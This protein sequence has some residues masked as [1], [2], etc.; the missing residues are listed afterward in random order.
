MRPAEGGS[1]ERIGGGEGESESTQPPTL[2]PRSS[3]SHCSPKR[4]IPPPPQSKPP[5]LAAVHGVDARELEKRP[6]IGRRRGRGAFHLRAEEEE[7]IM[8]DH[9]RRERGTGRSAPCLVYIGLRWADAQRW[10]RGGSANGSMGK[11]KA[12]PQRE[13]IGKG[14][15]ATSS[16]E[17]LSHLLP[18]FSPSVGEL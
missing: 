6:Q 18:L 16:R 11:E 4:C 5:R 1:S 7:T 2:P 10:G 17:H 8:L 13:R 14:D 15:A 3:L 9:Q 12:A